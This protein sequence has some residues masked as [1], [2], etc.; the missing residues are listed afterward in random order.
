MSISVKEAMNIGGLQKAKIIAGH[1]GVD[2]LIE[3]VSVIEVPESHEWFRGKE[4]F[5]T[6]F[7]TIKNNVEA[8]LDLIK[9]IHE[10]NVSAL[11]VCYPG[12]YYDTIP[13]EVIKMADEL[14]IPII[15]IPREVAYIEIISPVM[16]RIQKKQTLE[17]HQALHIQNHLHKWLAL[18]LDLETIA[19]NISELLQEDI[20]IVD[21]Q[22][23]LLA[24]I[25]HDKDSILDIFQAA[26]ININAVRSSQEYPYTWST[27]QVKYYAYPI[28]T[29]D[30]IYGYLILMNRNENSS[31]K[32]LIYDYLSTS[33]ALFFSQKAV[34][35]ETKRS[36]LKTLIDQWLTGDGITPEIFNE[37][38]VNLGWNME[39]VVGISIL[40]VNE[41]EMEL[42]R[43]HTL[44]QRFF[45]KKGNES[46]S[47]IYGQRILMLLKRPQGKTLGYDH[48]YQNIFQELYIILMEQSVNKINIAYTQESDNIILE[49]RELYKQVLSIVSFQLKYPVLPHILFAPTV[50]LF[51]FL[52]EN[53]HNPPIN[54]LRNLLDPL[55]QYD[56]QYQTD[57]I[58]TL[59]YMLFTEDITYLSKKLN[60]HRNTLNYRRQRIKDILKMNP[61]ES[62]Y[63]L[64]YELA[65]LLRK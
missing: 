64:Q 32:S 9:T 45:A 7:Y 15:E 31:L 56:R 10:K 30:K 5:L 61:F 18:Q 40:S 13:N 53:F 23:S 34:I 14:S 52:E 22:F 27:N 60:I 11:G 37:R 44:I 46:I 26:D 16:E 54:R 59:E 25:F 47:F 19:S 21:H 49:G 39:E 8:Q 48:Y 24:S 4:L 65:I 51:S 3:H 6:A 50:P 17:I 57:L 38:A 43:V 41:D 55:E 12:M 1:S 29:G 36:H 62:P 58:E 35:E 33:L 2:K 28:R 20:L 63:R 42:D